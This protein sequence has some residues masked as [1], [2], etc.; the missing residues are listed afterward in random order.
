M[1]FCL[2]IKIDSRSYESKGSL[3]W[4]NRNAL[5]YNLD[6]FVTFLSRSESIVSTNEYLYKS[7]WVLVNQIK[8]SVG[9]FEFLYLIL[10]F[11][12]I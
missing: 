2:L 7:A 9:K 12:R 8:T 6:I 11:I 10:I 4:D 1:A 3:Y 5:W